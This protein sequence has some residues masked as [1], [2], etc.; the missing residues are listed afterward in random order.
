[1][2][3]AAV[4]VL[5]A[6]RLRGVRASLAHLR[7][8]LARVAEGYAAVVEGVSRFRSARVGLVG[9]RPPWMVY[10][11]VNPEDLAK[12]GV[13]M[14]EIPLEELYSRYRGVGEGEARRA[15]GEY[16]GSIRGSLTVEGLVRAVRLHMALEGLVADYGLDAFTVECFRVIE[17][18]GVSP[19]LS[20]A[21]HN[22]RGVVA[23]CEGDLNGLLGM[24][25]AS[26]VSGEPAFMGNLADL[27]DERTA[28]FA[29]C[30]APLSVG[31]Y[32]LTTH[33]ESGGPLGVAVEPP[34]GAVVTV[35]K[36]DPVRGWF[37]VS[38]GVVSGGGGRPGLC[39]SQYVVGF[40]GGVG[41]MVRD[42]PGNHYVVVLGDYVE[43]LVLAGELLGY[44][45]LVR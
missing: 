40:E 18:L 41:W 33:F 22:S 45:V 1:S 35:L 11:V 9:G 37:I 10:S 6:L 7:G 14:V 39:R 23:G 8:D 27:V 16:L 25:A 19:C 4:E 44:S 13:E 32:T 26:Y 5:P 24:M 34:V 31:R 38:R 15:A 20:L 21:I 36:V 3:A 29:H 43:R 42:S 28:V 17:A 2:L 12:L 30:T